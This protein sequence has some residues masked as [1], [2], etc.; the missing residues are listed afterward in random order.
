MSSGKTDSKSSP[1]S[2]CLDCIERWIREGDW[3]LEIPE[4]VPEPDLSG[5]ECRWKEIPGKHQ[6]IINLLIQVAPGRTDASAIYRD[7]LQWITETFGP[8]SERHPLT[9]ESLDLLT[10][11]GEQKLEVDF[12]NFEKPEWQRKVKRGWNALENKVGLHLMKKGKRFLGVDWADYFEGVL[13][14]GDHQK[15]NGMLALT[16]STTTEKRKALEANL[17]SAFEEGKL[18]YGI[19]RTHRV[20]ITCMVMDRARH[21]RHF[22]DGYGSGYTQAARQLKERLATLAT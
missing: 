17:Q 16:S 20:V 6:E 13:K 1:A 2:S 14:F 5:L 22:V 11:A 9:K 3:A 15:F 10:R 12:R 19:H 7:G 18:A 8:E 4:E 21:H